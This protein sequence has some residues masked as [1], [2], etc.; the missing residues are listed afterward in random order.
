MPAQQ[1]GRAE[2]MWTAGIL[3]GQSSSVQL[4]T[5][6][7][8]GGGAGGVWTTAVAEGRRAQ[9]SFLPGASEAT[10]VAGCQGSPQLENC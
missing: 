7:E 9:Y 3:Q 8:C 5:S 4:C 6:G 2:G 10:K 1:Q